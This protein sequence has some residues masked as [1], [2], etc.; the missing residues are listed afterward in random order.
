MAGKPNLVSIF[1]VLKQLNEIGLWSFRGRSVLSM[2]EFDI[3]FFF[4]IRVIHPKFQC[5]NID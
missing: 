2:F 5:L 4:E 1:V 3:Y